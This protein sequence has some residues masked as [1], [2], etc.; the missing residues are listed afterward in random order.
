MTHSK[1]SVGRIVH[2]RSYGSPGGEYGQHCRAAIV[3]EVSADDDSKLVGLA[4]INPT[5]LF[6][7]SLADGGCSYHDGG[8]TAG[9][10]DCQERDAH[11]KPFRYCSCGWAEA[12]Y[13]GGTWHWVERV[14]E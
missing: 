4:V 8:E 2:Y 5:G 14:E 10:A 1:P 6:F 11:G 13:P 9:A 3:T 7:H 12:S